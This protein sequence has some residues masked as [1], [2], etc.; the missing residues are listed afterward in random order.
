[1]KKRKSREKREKLGQFTIRFYAGNPI[2]ES[3]YETLDPLAQGMLRITIIEALRL[4]LG[5]LKKQGWPLLLEKKT[6]S[7]T[8][9]PL[10]SQSVPSMSES[11]NDS[12]AIEQEKSAL[13][14]LMS[15][16]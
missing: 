15:D 16:E 1:M 6:A 3:I 13:Q 7:V 5:S 8:Q 12:P 9:A 10:P 11:S 14:Q 2:D 4:G